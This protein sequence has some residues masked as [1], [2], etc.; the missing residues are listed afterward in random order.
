MAVCVVCTARSRCRSSCRSRAPYA[1]DLLPGHPGQES[2]AATSIDSLPRCISSEPSA[3]SGACRA[4]HRHGFL[5]V[6]LPP[7]LAKQVLHLQRAMRR[8]FAR[9]IPEKE[10]YRTP[11]DG[12]RVLSHPGYLTPSPGWQELFEIRLSQCDP[13]YRLPAKCEEACKTAFDSLRDFTLLWLSHLS[14]HLCGDAAM[15][16]ALAASDS[17]PATLRAIHYDQVP[18]LGEQIRG[19]SPA[20]RPLAEER[21]VAGF[22]VHTDSGLRRSRRHGRTSPNGPQPSPPHKPNTRSFLRS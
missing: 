9:P 18:A 21:L 4:L 17:G 1:D 7:E 22:P 3:I 19:L 20:D 15:L 11:Q 12:E 16:P 13:A 2:V 8:F 6:R 5:I 10:S 14:A